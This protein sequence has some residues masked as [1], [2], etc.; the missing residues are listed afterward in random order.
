[1]PSLNVIDR[2]SSPA[3]WLFLILVLVPLVPTLISSIDTVRAQP[4]GGDV[5]SSDSGTGKTWWDV[6]RRDYPECKAL[7]DQHEEMTGELYRLDAEAKQAVE[8][9]RKQIVQQI[10]DLS[11]QRTKVQKQIF[12][13][14][15]ESS[16]SRRSDPLAG[17][18]N[19]EGSPA[20][21]SDGAIRG[22]EILTPQGRKLLF[23][24][25]AEMNEIAKDQAGHSDPGSEFLGGLAEWAGETLQLLAQ[26]P[27]APV[28]QMAKG[29]MDYLTNDNAANHAA[30]RAAAEQAVR[31]F[32]ENPARFLGK[33]LPDVLPTPGSA[34]NKARALQR[35]SQAEK[36]AA[37]IKRMA[38]AK[39]KLKEFYKKVGPPGQG[40]G[41]DARIRACS[42]INSCVDKA[43]AEAQL[44]KTGGPIGDGTPWDIVGVHNLQTPKFPDAPSGRPPLTP[45]SPN[46]PKGRP[47]DPNQPL[48]DLHHTREQ[49]YAKLKP[50][51]DGFK[52]RQTGTYNPEQLD[53]IWNGEPIPM[54]GPEHIATILEREG[55]GSQGL[56]MVELKRP[57]GDV[58]GHVV[59]F[60]N[61]N[62]KVTV[63]DR[64]RLRIDSSEVEN[65]FFFPI[66]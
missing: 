3:R 33:N 16:R 46:W 53:M 27:G 54:K 47:Y 58:A 40:Y 26:K 29:I 12:A 34:A 22:Q 5:F 64:T 65:W 21:R 31:E 25:S 36:A 18:A 15:R 2:R 56:V 19:D 42:A 43:L 1:M 4:T 10:N 20:E 17:D 6:K 63:V 44:F 62:G 57:Q 61:P 55:V 13:C 7:V 35:V 60:Q 45:D 8:P 28:E 66:Y 39:N 23:Q 32:Q 9:E 37:R 51:G 11:R 38:D 49:L 41:P 48:L 59:N 14:I 50:Y 24:L 30:L 52:P